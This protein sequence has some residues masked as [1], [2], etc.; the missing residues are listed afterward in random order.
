MYKIFYTWERKDMTPWSF[1]ERS[2]LA[3]IIAVGFTGLFYFQAVYG[4][5]AT[6]NRNPA[7]MATVAIVSVVL[8]IVIE[9]IYHAIIAGRGD[10]ETHDERDR[11]IQLRGAWVE[12]LVLE[13]G[14]MGVIGHIVIASQFDRM[15]VDLFL[16]GN[17][18]VAVLVAS[19]MLGRGLELIL[20]RRGI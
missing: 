6:G 11:S 5:L 12:K 18:L 17:L 9:A 13:I 3:T 16:V 4:M 1:N 14:V 2:R 19:E 7:E 8:L 20:Y 15:N 10:E